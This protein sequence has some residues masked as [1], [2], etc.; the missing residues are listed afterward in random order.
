MY[1]N[2][3]I[4]HLRDCDKQTPSVQ[5][6]PPGVETN[7]DS[8]SKQ[9]SGILEHFDCL[10]SNK[11]ENYVVLISLPATIT[12]TGIYNQKHVSG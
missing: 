4:D 5:Q 6:H 7:Q 12:T 8:F 10:H 3:L 1:V 2:L 11:Q 9:N